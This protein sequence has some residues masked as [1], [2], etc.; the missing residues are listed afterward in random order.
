MARSVDFPKSQVVDRL[1]K[2]SILAS[3]TGRQLERLAKWVKVMAY[4]DGET[5]VKRGEGGIGLYLILEGGAEV[6][7]GSRHLA[8]FG[9]GQFFGEMSLFDEQPR[10][11]DVVALQPTKCAVLTRWEFWAFATSTPTV[12]RGVLVEMTRRLRETNQALSE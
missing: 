10:S 7:R 12:L 5:I 6:R 11:A 1:A 3:L 4:D 9:V 2:V 8:R